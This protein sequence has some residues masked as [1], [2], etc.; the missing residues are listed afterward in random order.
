MAIPRLPV[1]LIRVREESGGPT[2][3]PQIAQIS[4]NR[5]LVSE[6]VLP[7]D[8]DSSAHLHCSA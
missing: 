4:Q 2:I 8:L 6:V 7:S 3:N 1:P 5:C